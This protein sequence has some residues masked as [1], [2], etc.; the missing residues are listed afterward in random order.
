MDGLHRFELDLFSI[1][2]NRWSAYIYTSI[3]DSCENFTNEVKRGNVFKRCTKVDKIVGIVL[4]T[5]HFAD[6]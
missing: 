4:Y 2:C 1:L 5:K 3:V 6:V